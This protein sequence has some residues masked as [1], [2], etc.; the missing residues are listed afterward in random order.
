MRQLFRM[1]YDPNIGESYP[2][3]EKPKRFDESE[4]PKMYYHKDELIGLG[5]EQ[6]II[7]ITFTNSNVIIPWMQDKM[8][9]KATSM[10]ALAID[11]KKIYFKNSKV[12]YVFVQ[13]D[14]VDL[15]FKLM[16]DKELTEEK[17]YI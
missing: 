14:Q 12:E 9:A 7:R 11:Y 15:F 6:E 5:T 2:V 10:V 8:E 17:K 3:Y 4:S 13:M 1:E 16:M